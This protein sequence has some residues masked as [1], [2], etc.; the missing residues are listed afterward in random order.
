MTVAVV[1][2][3]NVGDVYQDWIDGVQQQ[4][5]ELGIKLDVYNADGD[6]AKQALYMEQ[7]VASK[8]D[9]ILIGWGFGDSLAPG[10][11]LAEDAG[12][13]VVS[14]YVQVEPSENVLAMDQ[15]DDLMMKEILAQMLDHTGE[16]ADI[17]YCYV[18]GYQ[19]LDNRDVE[20]QSFLSEHSGLNQ[21]AQIGVVSSNTAAETADQA[22]AALTA[23][24]NVTAIV[25]PWDEFA[26]GAVLAVEELGL[27]DKVKVYGIDISTADIAVMTKDGSPWVVTG[28]TDHVN[29][30][31]VSMRTMALKI[32]D[33]VDGNV[34]SIPPAIITQ[35]QL[36]AA[37]IQNM[38]QLIAEVPDLF[39]PDLMRAPWMAK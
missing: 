16:D 9:G 5:D 20:Y 36:R 37:S 29:V 6:N 32:A 35:D 28:T 15:G 1:R 26:K 12:I 31:Q 4:A 19:A 10:L 17:I 27:Q 22:K 39:T 24:P 3:L 25:A 7:A 13:P 34:L 8:P 18:P 33:Q 23:N 11:K 30:G 38:D 14:Y 21:V 2:Q